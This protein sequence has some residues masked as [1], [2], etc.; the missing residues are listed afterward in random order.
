MKAPWIAAITLG[1]GPS[2]LILAEKSSKAEAGQ[3][4]MV[5][6]QATFPP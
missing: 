6:A 5:A 2:G 4:A 1:G 3:P